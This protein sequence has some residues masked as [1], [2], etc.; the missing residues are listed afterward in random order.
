M[1]QYPNKCSRMPMSSDPQI[2]RFAEAALMRDEA[3]R[4]LDRLTLERDRCEQ[5]FAEAGRSDP[6]KVVTGRT[7]MDNAVDDTRDMIRHMDELLA[8]TGRALNRRMPARPARISP[9]R[10]GS[11]AA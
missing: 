2:R 9:M 7:A 4:L 5:R 1:S 10:V 6:L 11:G 3:C 8:E